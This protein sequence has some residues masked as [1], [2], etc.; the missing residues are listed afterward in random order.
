LVSKEVKVEAAWKENEETLSQW[1]FW[2]RLQTKEPK[3]SMR[4]RQ[5]DA[6]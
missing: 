2:R 1:T 5:R 4:K 3:S 6:S